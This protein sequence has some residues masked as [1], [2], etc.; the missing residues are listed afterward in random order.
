MTKTDPT[1]LRAGK[2]PGD[3]LERMLAK[4]HTRRDQSVIV[5]TSYG[6]DAAA[7][8]VGDETLL[9]KSDPITFASSDAARYL[10]AVN[11]NDIACL[12]G[13]P[14]WLTVVALLPEHGTTVELVEGLFAD[15]Q[16]ACELEDI[17]LIGGHTE[18]TLGVDRPLLIGTLLGTVGPNGLLKPGMAHAGDELWL[19]HNPGIEG[20]A[21]LAF[22]REQELLAAF[23]PDIVGAAK[24]LLIDPGISVS[25]DA[26]ALIQ[27][28]I[29]TA[30]HDAT[31]GGVATAIHEIAAAS[32]L[33]AAI[34]G[35]AIP[36]LPETA[37]IAGYYGL[38][39]LGLISSGA[40]IIACAP[41]QEVVMN[42]A[43]VP[44]T[45]IGV[46]TDEPGRVTISTERGEDDLHR[47]DSDEL[48][49]ALAT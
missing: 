31:E 34:D 2:L 18:I 20:T 39:P 44:V 22:E 43:M 41:G 9:V 29:I 13:V 49:R 12:G 36:I 48:A 16:H 45:R 4:Y 24:A 14:R 26:N 11:A 17:S 35:A 46:L 10:V 6:F 27:M 25:R 21:L 28:G 8:R 30:L 38:D 15:L 1:F 37:A 19:S 32:G 42:T 40:L 33:G 23:G 7:V 3:M 5:N 47:F